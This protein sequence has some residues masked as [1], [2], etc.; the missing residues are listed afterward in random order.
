MKD[1]EWEN[2]GRPNHKYQVGEKVLLLT[3]ANERGGK[4]VDFQHIYPNKVIKV[5]GNW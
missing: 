5:Y 1:N 2:K 3:C 4:L